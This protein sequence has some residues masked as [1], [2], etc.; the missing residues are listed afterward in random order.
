MVTFLKDN[1][2]FIQKYSIKYS[3][4]KTPLENVYAEIIDKMRLAAENKKSDILYNFK[5]IT[6]DRENIKNQI[7]NM[8]SKEKINIK[9]YKEIDKYL[10][11]FS[12]NDEK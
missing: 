3:N 1:L 10:Y 5:F 9:H 12:W 11:I 6:E 8:L 7:L 4:R 2:H